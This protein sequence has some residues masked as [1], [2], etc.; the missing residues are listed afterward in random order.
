ML[1]YFDCFSGISGD[2]TLGALVDLGVPADWLKETIRSDLPLEGFEMA[3]SST[4]RH[5]ITACQ[6]TVQTRDESVS[7]NYRDIRRLLEN[8]RLGDAVK[9]NSLAVF[10]RLATAEARIHGCP[11][12]TV[13]FHEVGG[14]D[15][16]V[17]IV[18]TALGFDY[19]GVGRIIASPLPAGGGFVKA[20][21][22]MLPLPAPATLE[23]LREVPIYGSDVQHELVTPTGAAI[24]SA[25][26]EEF[27][28]LPAM[29]VVR[30]GYGA[31]CADLAVQPNLLR[32]ILGQ[33]SAGAGENV[34]VV[35]T[36][37]DDMNPELF[38]YLMDRLFEDGALDVFWVPIQMKKNRPGTMVQVIC[39]TGDRA[40][41]VNR[42]LSETTTIGVR[43]HDVQRFTLKRETVR[44]AT[45]FGDIRAKRITQPDGSVRLAPEYD[46]CRE[47][48]KRL[49]IPIRK[50]YETLLGQLAARDS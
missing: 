21:H 1:A 31:G 47:I 6:V 3:V 9:K 38:G 36:G 27:G 29:R 37:I 11:V 16:L 12:D 14:I 5:G 44:V 45:S 19:L 22:G 33:P 35:E 28:P 34:T 18:G 41:I 26:A 40:K 2:M 43:C 50:V 42:L 49:D 25:L 32:L 10:Q 39:R 4:V 48:A 15:A 46:E 8:S 23:I 30:I 24:V 20:G 13:H 17:D 7:R